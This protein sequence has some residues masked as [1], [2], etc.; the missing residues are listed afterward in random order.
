MTVRQIEYLID[1]IV[2]TGTYLPGRHGV[3]VHAL[4]IMPSHILWIRLRLVEQGARD[5]LTS[6]A[7]NLL[8]YYNI[9]ITGNGL[10]KALKAYNIS[11][12]KLTR[13]NR[14]AFTAAV[15]ELTR[16]FLLRRLTLRAA[17]GCFADEMLYKS[18]QVGSNYGYAATNERA[19][20]VDAGRNSGDAVMP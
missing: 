11:W 10:G 18:E 9:Q 7:S 8:F 12:K 17:E 20:Q 2:A 19:I 3:G 14:C 5:D 1:R 13:M 15:I 4:K 6:M 16:R